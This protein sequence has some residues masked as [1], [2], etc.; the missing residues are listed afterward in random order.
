MVKRYPRNW[1]PHEKEEEYFSLLTVP[2]CRGT[3]NLGSPQARKKNRCTYLV[4]VRLDLQCNGGG[5]GK[6]YPQNGGPHETTEEEET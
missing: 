1:T 4:H 3:Q 2:P 6:P 5:G